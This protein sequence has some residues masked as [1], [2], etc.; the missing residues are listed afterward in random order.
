[1]R[2]LCIFDF[3]G[4]LANTLFSIAYF[5]N[6]SL[7]QHG[8]EP[9]AVEDYRWMVGN[10][11]VVLL[12]RMV[13]ASAGKAPEELVRQVKETYDGLYDSAPS[14]M[15]E[16]YEGIPHVLEE[17]KRQGWLLGINSNKPDHLTKS[18]AHTVFAGQE[19]DFIL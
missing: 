11:A 13:K 4:T 16:P 5:G 17:L 15:V 18:I 7:Q 1:M 12:H 14:H 9:L 8:L 19:F 10:G 2:R 6:Q 3:D